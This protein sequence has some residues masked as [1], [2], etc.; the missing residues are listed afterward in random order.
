MEIV[1]AKPSDLV[2]IL[3]LVRVCIKDMNSR[4]IKHWNS[5]YP[6][7]ELLQKD[8]SDESIYL[9][10]DKGVCKGMISLV[11]SQPEEYKEVEDE[12]KGS[13]TLYVLRLAVHPGWQGQGIAGM[14]IDFSE[15]YAKENGFKCIQLD[16]F[17]Q[18]I[19]GVE[20][21]TERNY[22]EVGKFY[23]NFQKTPFICYEKKL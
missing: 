11:T 15:K 19:K 2:E 8:L 10:K 21:Y 4:G 3:Y 13:K 7:A 14:M 18:E 17:S 23:S 12:D 22:S 1:K 5:A 20:V 6:D 9:A 16:V